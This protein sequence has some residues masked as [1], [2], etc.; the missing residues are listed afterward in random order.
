MS[1]LNEH[2]ITAVEHELILESATG[3]WTEAQMKAVRAFSK[4]LKAALSA[5][6]AATEGEI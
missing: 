2:D 5:K 3:Q 6:L 4:R 1:G